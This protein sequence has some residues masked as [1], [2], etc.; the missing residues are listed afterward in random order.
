MNWHKDPECDRAIISLFD[1]ICSYERSTG[2]ESL[3]V[4]I[5]IEDDEPIV[6]SDSGK[7]AGE[8]TPE[9]VRFRVKHALAAHDN[10]DVHHFIDCDEDGKIS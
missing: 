5:P 4:I 10:S 9:T 1:A 3:I 6:L 7:P 2:R 8:V